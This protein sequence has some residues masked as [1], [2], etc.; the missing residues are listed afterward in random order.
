MLTA[1][2][3]AEG[4]FVIPPAS[5]DRRLQPGQYGVVFKR[6]PENGA[7]ATAIPKRFTGVQTSPL[8]IEIVP[9]VNSFSFDLQSR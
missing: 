8:I 1:T 2:T 3:D 7:P 9:G 5:G 6:G 4:R